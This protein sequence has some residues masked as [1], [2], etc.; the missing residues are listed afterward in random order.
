MSAAT[1]QMARTLRALAALLAYPERELIEALPELRACV[2]ASVVPLLD[3]LAAQDLLQSQENYVG[4]FDRSRAL[5]LQ[6]FEHVHGESRDRGQ[7]M[8][9]LQALY[10]ARGMQVAD[11]EMPDFI[12]AFLEYLSLL[13]TAEAQPLLGETSHI[14]RGIGERLAE[15]GTGYAEVF[16]ALLAIAGEAGLRKRAAVAAPPREDRDALD[17]QWMDPEVSF[18]GPQPIQIHRTKRP[19]EAASSK[20]IP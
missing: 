19:P 18:G 3:E 12:P 14:L 10:E 2:P 13:E 5:S 17:R 11:G 4:L 8:V 7:A 20:V 6:L 15:R 1:M 9:D 16:A